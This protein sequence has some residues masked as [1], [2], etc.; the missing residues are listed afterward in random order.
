MMIRPAVIVKDQ[1]EVQN[2]KKLVANLTEKLR[3]YQ[4]LEP[5]KT[6]PQLD[7]DLVFR[8]ISGH[9]LAPLLNEYEAT[10]TSQKTEI[11]SLRFEL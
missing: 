7:D 11:D 4:H 2:L 5:L 1:A 8:S 3:H 6:L 10:I 9:M